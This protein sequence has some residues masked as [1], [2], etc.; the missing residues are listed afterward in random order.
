MTPSATLR[1]SVAPT[2]PATVSSTLETTLPT[3]PVT[4]GRGSALERPESLLLG[5]ADS[6]PPPAVDGG[7]DAEGAG[8]PAGL[9]ETDL[10]GEVGP[11][12]AIAREPPPP[13]PPGWA[14]TPDRAGVGLP[15]TR[16]GWAPAPPVALAARAALN[17]G[18]PAPTP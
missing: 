16:E 14:I 5:S 7:A 6:P 8:A 18:D 2:V 12:V 4:P 13:K 9:G 3:L 1:G 11:P 10:P 17:P 15:P